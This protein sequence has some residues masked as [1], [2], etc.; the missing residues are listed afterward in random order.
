MCLD[1]YHVII[2]YYNSCPYLVYWKINLF[3]YGSS[4]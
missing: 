1:N 2:Y 3:I 4:I